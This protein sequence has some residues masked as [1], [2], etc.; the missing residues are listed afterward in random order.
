MLLQIARVKLLELLERSFSM[1]HLPQ[2][3]MVLVARRNE[4][5]WGALSDNA[6][7]PWAMVGSI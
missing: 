5:M 7:A 1:I 3:K 4:E 2:T 6:A